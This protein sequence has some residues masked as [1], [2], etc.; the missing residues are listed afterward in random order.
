[1]PSLYLLLLLPA[2]ARQS[3]QCLHPQNKGCLTNDPQAKSK[4][5]WI[6]SGIIK[7]VFY[8]FFQKFI[9][10]AMKSYSFVISVQSDALRN[11][12][13]WVKQMSFKA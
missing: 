6:I 3:K 13:M 12:H 10:V 1:M 9:H 2:N 5:K 11:L 4:S 8:N 7:F